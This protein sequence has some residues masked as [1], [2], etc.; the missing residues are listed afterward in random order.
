METKES[1]KEKSG[2]KSE[3]NSN[4]YTSPVHFLLILTGFIVV[5]VAVSILV[6]NLIK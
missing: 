4:K 2:K 1:L 5:L 3:S 6:I